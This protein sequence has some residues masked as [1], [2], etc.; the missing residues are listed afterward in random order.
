LREPREFCPKRQA[1]KLR[2]REIDQRKPCCDRSGF[3][4]AA[5][6][7]H[8]R[9][10]CQPPGRR[11]FRTAR[12]IARQA[13]ATAIASIPATVPASMSRMIRAAARSVAICMVFSDE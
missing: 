5:E 2:T 3:E 10:R 12:I 7:E 13:P 1:R 8:D 6:V 9:H 11:I 4:H